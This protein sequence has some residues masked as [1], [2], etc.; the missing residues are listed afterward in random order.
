[1]DTNDWR[2]TKRLDQA[3]WKEVNK[4]RRTNQ[5]FLFERSTEHT[6]STY[7]QYCAVHLLNLWIVFGFFYFY[8]HFFL[9]MAT[10]Q[11]MSI[12]SIVV[13]IVFF[14]WMNLSPMRSFSFFS[15]SIIVWCFVLQCG[16]KY[17][18]ISDS[19][20]TNCRQTK[21]VHCGTASPFSSSNNWHNHMRVNLLSLFFIYKK[22]CVRTVAGIE[23]EFVYVCQSQSF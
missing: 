7:R 14:F 15:L 6:R 4:S 10:I 12:F 16:T 13:E 3:S 2:Y 8:F 9:Y 21:C 11:W 20:P 1:M 17:Y 22:K 19:S 23:C 5:F 18:T